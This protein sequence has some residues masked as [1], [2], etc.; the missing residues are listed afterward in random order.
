MMNTK[1]ICRPIQAGLRQWRKY[2]PVGLTL[3]LPRLLRAED[4]VDYR[5]EY[6]AEDN[7]RMTIETH[8]VY[9]EQKLADAVAVKGEVVYDSISGAT[10]LG[11]HDLKGNIILAHVKDTRYAGNLSLDTKLGNNTL[12]PGF[13]YS[14]EHDYISYGLSL[15]D[16]IEFNDKNTTL[17]LGASHNFDSVRHADKVTWSDKEATEGIIGITQLLTPKTILAVDATFGNESGYLSDPYRLAQYHPTV[18]PTGFYIGVPERR[19]SN[20]SKEVLFTSL[21]QYFETVDASLEGSYR[22]Y[23]DSYGVLAHTVGLT[24]HQWLG[25]HLMVEPFFRVYEQ[26]AASFYS[27]TFSG[28]LPTNPNQPAGFHS[29]DYRLSHFYSLDSGLQITGVINDHFHVVAGYHRYEMYGLDG[30]TS[31]AMYPKA[32]VFTVGVS[33][34]W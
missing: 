10:P 18:F 15:N 11:T 28:P 2:L 8:S 33:L 17:Q 13:A 6:Y 19:P 4:Q 9:F 30:K 23:N 1:N 5:Y 20:R 25:K 21:T 22:L 3:A 29:S 14:Q 34:L 12:T 24:W 7:N 26:S 31:A 32:N 16:A 27:T